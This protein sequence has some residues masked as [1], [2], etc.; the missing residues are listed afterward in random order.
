MPNA[1]NNSLSVVVQSILYTPGTN[2][3]T[4]T[5]SFTPNGIGFSATI[6]SSIPYLILPNDIC[7]KFVQAFNLG[8]DRSK[9]IYT[10]NATSHNRNLLEN[11]TVSFR[12]GVSTQNNAKFTTIVLP[13][14]AFD[15]QA[16][17][18]IYDNATNYFPI[19]NSTNGKFVLGRTFLQETYL[20][21]DYERANFTVAPARFADPM[22]KE[23]LVTIFN[24]TYVQSQ[25]GK[26]PS[27]G[28][29][30]AGAVA[31]IVVGIVAVLLILGILAF[32]Y[33]KKRQNARAR[34]LQDEGRPSEIDTMV[35]GGEIKYRRVS[36]LTGSEA[37][38]SPSSVGATYYGVDNKKYPAIAEMSP[39]SRPAE[40][41]S[42]PLG[43]EN[44]DYFAAGPKPRR[45]GATRSSTGN[46]SPGTPVAELAGDCGQPQ[47]R[48]QHSRSPSDTSLTT[49]IDEVLAGKGSET[50]QVQRKGSSRFIEHT[51][52]DDGPSRSAQ[53]VSPID[54]SLSITAI[55]Q[56]STTDPGNRPS[57]TRGLSDTTINSDSTAVSQPTPEELARWAT[58]PDASRRPLSQ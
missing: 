42:P 24:T 31:G 48:P 7:N 19:R 53:V 8:Y 27:G 35:A 37:P 54:D 57:H 44:D 28:G 50:Q 6:D 25:Q 29:L 3:P 10:V 30:S 1:R 16:S 11:A 20:I 58:N 47:E 46:N 13:Y 52:D 39:E 9:G 21:V 12:I 38:T 22:P 15:L 55:E 49:N 5:Q 33:W 2:T 17:F 43:M 40:L 34:S 26:S 41:Y 14:L 51:G 18:P 45:R 23:D 4:T 56:D 32:F 36:E